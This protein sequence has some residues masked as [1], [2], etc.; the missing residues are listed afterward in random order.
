MRFLCWFGI[1]DWGRQQ[2]VRGGLR[3]K[4]EILLALIEFRKCD[5]TCLRCG[6]TKTFTYDDRK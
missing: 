4:M 5:R 6:K 3:G 1:H 2:N